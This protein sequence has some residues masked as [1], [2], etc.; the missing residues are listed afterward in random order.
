MSGLDDKVALVTGSSRGIGAAIA[1][2][3]AQR[4]AKVA[5]HGRDPTALSAVQAEIGRAGG[6]AIRVAADVTKFTDIRPCVFR[7]NENSG[8]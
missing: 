6:R 5:V 4:G 8:Q 1:S 7:S 2:L 3:F